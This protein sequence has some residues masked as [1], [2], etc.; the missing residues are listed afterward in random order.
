M[1]ASDEWIAEQVRRVK[2][3]DATDKVSDQAVA[4]GRMI[5]DRLWPHQ[6]PTSRTDL[7]A[8]I[9]C[10]FQTGLDHNAPD[11]VRADRDDYERRWIAECRAH[12]ATRQRLEARLFAAQHELGDH[13]DCH[14][15][16]RCERSMHEPDNDGF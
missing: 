14:D 7:A 3:G 11:Q 6:F 8:I 1:P 4:Y 9:A 15:P 5:A 2:G 12:G 10:A 16:E 13:S